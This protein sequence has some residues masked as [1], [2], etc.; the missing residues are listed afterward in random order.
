ME[1]VMKK[2]I[3]IICASILAVVSIAA[4]CVY[5]F[6]VYLPE[7]KAREDWEA[8]VKQYYNNRV[9]LFAEENAKY[10]PGE[11]DVAFLGDSLTEGYDVKRF[12]SEYTVVNRGIGGDTSFG[13]E[14]RLEVSVY[15][16]QPKVAVMLIGANN[17]DTAM[18]NY[19]DIL[20]G[21]RDNLPNTKIVLLSLTAMCDTWGRNNG[22]AIQNNVKIKKLAS[23]YGYEFVDLFTPLYNLETEEIYE[24]YTTD[25][26]HLT[27]AGYEVLT[28]NIKPVLNRLLTK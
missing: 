23:I 16:L 5:H 26:G 24:E 17:F 6:A 19:E 9:E 12:Y 15:E 18:D 11:V 4:V 7:K 14:D 22:K 8:L 25:G 2:R 28:A 10:K 21:F 27:E 3:I 13:L 1:N 20:K